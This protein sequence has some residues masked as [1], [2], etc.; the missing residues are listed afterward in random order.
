MIKQ[1]QTKLFDFSDVGLDFCTGSKNKFPEV[2][3]KMLATGFNPQTVLSVVIND[4]QITLTYGVSHGYVADRVLQVTASGG[5]DKEV[6]ID[7]VNGQSITC[8]VLDGNTIGLTGT[9]NTK[10]ASLGWELMYELTNIHVYKMKHIDDTDRYVRLCFQNQ[11]S[12]V[13]AIAVCIGKSFDSNTGF[14]D[15][16]LAFQGTKDVTNPIGTGWKTAWHN[17]QP[18]TSAHNNWTYAQGLS[19]YGK[20][21]VVGSPYHLFF[22]MTERHGHNI[23][24]IFPHASHPYTQLDYPV[25]ITKGINNAA[26]SNGGNFATSSSEGVALVGGVLCR[27]NVATSDT[28][29]LVRDRAHPIS[30]FLGS[31]LDSFNTTTIRPLELYHKTTSQHL[32]YVYGIGMCMFTDANKPSWHFSVAPFLSTD[33]DFNNRVVILGSGAENFTNTST[34]VGVPVEAI[35]HGI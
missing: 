2:F 19:T 10:I 6:Y 23:Y 4:D 24:G 5:F 15:D 7:S 31:D 22:N 32:G 26:P 12:Q 1:T 16:P 17:F 9:I 34:F 35:R 11:A 3:K 14:I 13:N 25:I 30:S 20:G 18:A 27:F 29:D 8:T 21:M 28:T 33:V